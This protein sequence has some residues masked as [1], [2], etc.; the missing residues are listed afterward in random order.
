M[1]DNETKKPRDVEKK[2][3]ELASLLNELLGLDVDWTKL[4][5]DDLLEVAKLFVDPDRLI[6]RI[7]K[8]QREA[9][10]V[11]QSIRS[12]TKELVKMVLKTWRGPIIRT[13][14]KLILEIEEPKEQKSE[15]DSEE[16]R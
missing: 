11:I 8:A 6:E 15:N 12:L 3:F 16:S 10:N 9:Q 1:T 13:L 14:R 5:L 2:K 4:S 7:Q